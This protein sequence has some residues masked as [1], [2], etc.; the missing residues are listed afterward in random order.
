MLQFETTNLLCG[1]CSRAIPACTYV[2]WLVIWGTMTMCESTEMLLLSCSVLLTDLY[3]YQCNLN[4]FHDDFYEICILKSFDSHISVVV[5]SFFEFGTVSKWFIREWINYFP[6]N[7]W[8]LWHLSKT[9]PL[10]VQYCILK[11]M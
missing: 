4:F 1:E 10:Q 7:P 5:S 2:V 8:F 11:T 6:N 9:M 3:C